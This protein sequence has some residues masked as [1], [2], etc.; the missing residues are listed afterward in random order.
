MVSVTQPAR[1]L[2][3]PVDGVPSSVEARHWGTPLVILMAAV[4]VAAVAWF[5]RWDATGKVTADLMMSGE[6]MRATEIEISEAIQQAERTALVAG[7]AKG[8]FV[9]PALVLLL[10]VVLKVTG[11]FLGRP[12]PFPKAFTA[13]AVSL[14]PVALYWLL[15]TV[16]TLAQH[17]VSEGIRDTLLP[18]HL[19]HL[20]TGKG[21]AL[22]RALSALDLFNL[23]SAVL[24]GLGFA[25]ATGM[26]RWKG[27]AV[28]LVLY[29]LYA[30][31]FMIGLPGM[32]GG[33]GMGG[34][35]GGP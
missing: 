8:I 25:E 26:K 9:M 35:R 16:A 2:M 34:E 6:L 7:V 4:S 28:G 15:F 1:V 23:W 32:S 14:L 3:D 24:L 12:A 5:F 13:A 21:P 17:S 19:G 10:A 22:L 20:I 11:W 33:P 30:C 29:A 31:V 27:V 18:T